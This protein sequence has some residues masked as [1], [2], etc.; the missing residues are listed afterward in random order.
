M[1]L[2]LVSTLESSARIF[3]SSAVL[4]EADPVVAPR[5]ED[6]AVPS[7]FV[8]G[9]PGIAAFGEPVGDVARGD[10][11]VPPAVPVVEPAAPPEELP[12]LPL[13]AIA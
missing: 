7:A 1:L 9:G 4:P 2:I 6:C 5:P 11:V 10:V 13:C 3:L 12:V 8:P